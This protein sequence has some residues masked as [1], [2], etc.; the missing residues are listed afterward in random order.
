MKLIEVGDTIL[1]SK[2]RKVEVLKIEKGRYGWLILGEFPDVARKSYTYRA[3][4]PHELPPTDEPI[5][6]WLCWEFRGN[7]ITSTNERLGI[8]ALYTL[9]KAPLPVS[10]YDKLW[11]ATNMPSERLP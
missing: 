11:A 5:R 3:Y 7:L 6:P 8:V 4:M 10:E 9:Y 1:N 2:G